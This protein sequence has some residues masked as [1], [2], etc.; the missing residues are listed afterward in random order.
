MSRGRQGLAGRV[1][2]WGFARYVRRFIRANF[3]AVRVSGQAALRDLGS[4]SVLVYVNHPG[5]W[6]PMTAVLMTQLFFP[7]KRFAA[8]MDSEA[9]RKYPILGSLGFFGL[10]RD[11]LVGVREFLRTGRELMRAGNVALWLTPSG[12]FHDVRQPAAFLPGLGHLADADFGGVLLPMAIEYTF[13]NERRPELLVRFGAAIDCRG[14]PEERQARS[15]QLERLLVGVQAELAAAAISRRAEAFET[16]LQGRGGIG[17]LYDV[18]R[19]LVAWARWQKFD[20]RHQ[21][22]DGH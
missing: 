3:N 22:S 21:G 2:Y 7:G 5:W 12:Q 20:D 19:R 1:L 9:L 15:E 4:T 13:W 8:P 11:S 10:S 6:D 18:W 17:G 16:V 14:L